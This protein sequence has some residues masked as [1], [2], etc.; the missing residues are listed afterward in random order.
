MPSWVTNIM[1][2]KGD[3]KD[4]Y[5][6]F[7]KYFKDGDFD[8]NNIIAEP[9]SEEECP[10][11]Y[12]LNVNPND[13]IGPNS[14]GKDWFNWYD[15]RL[16]NWG[17]KWNAR[18][19][20]FFDAP[21]GE[22]I[23][24]YK[25][26]RLEIRF[27]TPW[28]HP[29]GII[30]KILE[31]NPHLDIAFYSTGVVMNDTYQEYDSNECKYFI[32]TPLN[33]FEEFDRKYNFVK[34]GDSV[35]IFGADEGSWD[36]AIPALEKCQNIVY[37]ADEKEANLFFGEELDFERTDVLLYAS[38]VSS[39]S[40][41]DRIC[42]N[43]SFGANLLAGYLY[44]SKLTE[45]LK[46]CFE[47]VIVEDGYLLGIDFHGIPIVIPDKWCL[48]LGCGRRVNQIAVEVHRKCPF[49]EATSFE[50]IDENR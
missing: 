19:V 31:D 33:T 39:N 16:V 1:V 45:K 41:F 5:R 7:V 48:C 6:F 40:D 13:R 15:W 3:S 32:E 42:E 25:S 37:D 28:G 10:E 50:P 29:G 22:S 34:R 30:C 26:N 14:D 23:E 8:F 47:E 49:C 35:L 18:Y 9:E 44:D 46:G 12:N 24:E 11:R 4:I 43:I 27:D 38:G 17:C 21:F 2:V 36:W 20:Q